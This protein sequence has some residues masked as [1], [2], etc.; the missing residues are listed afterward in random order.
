MLKGEDILRLL[1]NKELSAKEIAETLGC[2]HNLV[3]KPLERLEQKGLVL[4]SQKI[5][6]GRP[7]FFYS[8]VGRKVGSVCLWEEEKQRYIEDKIYPEKILERDY[9]DNLRQDFRI[10]RDKVQVR[11]MLIVGGVGNGKSVTGLSF[12]RLLTPSFSIRNVLFT[13]NDIQARIKQEPKKSTLLIDDM[14]TILSARGWQEKDKEKIWSYMQRCREDR[15]NFIGTAPN[16]NM[17]DIQFRSLIHYLFHVCLQCGEKGH[18]HVVVEK[19]IEMRGGA[20]REPVGVLRVDYPRYLQP[21]IDKYYEKKQKRQRLRLTEPTDK[22]E[23]AEKLCR[24]YVEKHTISRVSNM[25]LDAALFDSGL[26]EFSDSDRKKLKDFIF[27]VLEEKREKIRKE[28]Q[29]QEKRKKE[30][31]KQAQSATTLY[32]Q[33]INAGRSKGFA[34]AVAFPKVYLRPNYLENLNSAMA[35]LEE[36]VDPSSLEKV[37]LENLGDDNLIVLLKGVKTFFDEL[38]GLPRDLTSRLFWLF[39]YYPNK[40]KQLASEVASSRGKLS[41]QERERAIRRELERQNKQIA[42]EEKMAE[43]ISAIRRLL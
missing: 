38:K 41:K 39:V 15:V 40:L 7:V 30:K 20:G 28:E 9:W 10:V 17:V 8:S 4:R 37:V 12:A 5:V 6:Q 3:Y 35:P 16:L 31:E 27:Q 11:H 21:L 22:I 26:G 29:L 13:R 2:K 19:K 42:G 23:K 18:A 32:W 36:I 24:S 34:E 1:G 43:I 33:Y 14:G 25:A